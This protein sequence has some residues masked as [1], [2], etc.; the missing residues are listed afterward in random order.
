[1]YFGVSSIFSYLSVTAFV[2]SGSLV[3]NMNGFRVSTNFPCQKSTVE[4]M[5]CGSVMNGRLYSR[6]LRGSFVERT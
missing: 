4:S 2:V 3:Q 6:F 1:M 5:V